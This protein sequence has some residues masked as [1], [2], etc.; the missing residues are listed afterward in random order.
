MNKYKMGEH[1]HAI[2][3]YLGSY[4]I[5]EGY[6]SSISHDS[7]GYSYIFKDISGNTPSFYSSLA[8]WGEL[9]LFDNKEAAQAELACLEKGE[10]DYY[11]RW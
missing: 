9:Q 5:V 11:D 1:V 10:S 8:E 7:D 3:G 6:I 4:Y 2:N